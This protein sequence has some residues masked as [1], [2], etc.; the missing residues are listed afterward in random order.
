MV[1]SDPE[2]SE[3]HPQTSRASAVV[4]RR[5]RN[6]PH[7]CFHSH[8]FPPTPFYVT[9]LRSRRSHRC[10]QTTGW[11]WLWFVLFSFC[12]V[13]GFPRTLSGGFPARLVSG[14]RVQLHQVSPPVLPEEWEDCRRGRVACLNEQKSRKRRCC[15][16]NGGKYSAWSNM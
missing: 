4:R 11:Y 14:H 8:K 3:D 10:L 16:R 7:C 15:R 13:F 1:Q 12:P 5:V 6:F 2:A 9:S